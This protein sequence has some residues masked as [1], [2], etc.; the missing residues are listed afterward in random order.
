[1]TGRPHLCFGMY[2]FEP[3]R[4]AW[5][6]LLDALVALVPWLPREHDWAEDVHDAWVDPT[7]VLTQV[8]G[9]PLAV[10][11]H[12]VLRPI[13]AFRLATPAAEGHRYRSVLLAD[14]PGAPADFARPGVTAAANSVDSLSGWTSFVAGFVAPAGRWP[15]DVIWTSAHAE[16]LR[17]LRQGRAQVAAIDATSLALFRAADP[18]VTDGLFEIGRGPLIPSP[19]VAVRRG[20]TEEQVAELRGAF[21]ALMADPALAGARARLLIEGFVELDL[22]EYLPVRALTPVG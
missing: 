7:C 21:A 10:Q 6:A 2:P 15:G 14:R 13:G 5:D 17:A 12:D 20:A 19:P 3:L 8:C 22:E 11:H 18:T 9:G 1:M 16:S 4:P